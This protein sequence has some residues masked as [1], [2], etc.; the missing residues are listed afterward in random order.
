MLSQFFLLFS[1]SPLVVHTPLLRTSLRVQ[2][3]GTSLPRK[4]YSVKSL[5]KLLGNKIQFH[6]YTKQETLK[7]F[8]NVHYLGK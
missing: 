5:P 8:K 7:T 6:P 4:Q 2:D 1:T 3:P